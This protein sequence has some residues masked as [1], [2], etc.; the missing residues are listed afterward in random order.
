MEINKGDSRSIAD[1]VSDLKMDLAELIR[2]EVSLARV[3]LTEKSRRVKRG[4][5]ALVMGGV[6]ALAGAISLVAAAILA[7][8][9]V[10]EAPWLSSAIIGALLL[11]IGLLSLSAAKKHF[12]D[13]APRETAESL[14]RSKELLER[15]VTNR[16]AE[17]TP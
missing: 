16:P 12:G 9:Q 3:E 7:L 10:L 8:D 17:R 4:A 2:E 11:M 14:R 6:V 1:I 13:L 15:H 5:L